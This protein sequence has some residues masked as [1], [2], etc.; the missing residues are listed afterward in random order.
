MGSV[1]GRK[2]L[3]EA[4]IDPLLPLDQKWM[5]CRLPPARRKLSF[6]HKIEED[7][8]VRS[9]IVESGVE[10][11]KKGEGGSFELVIAKAGMEELKKTL[12]L[13]MPVEI[14]KSCP[15]LPASSSSQFWRSWRACSACG[16]WQT[17]HSRGARQ[18]PG[19]RGARR[20]AASA[21]DT[22]SVNRRRRFGISESYI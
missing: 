9:A 22:H 16:G 17:L 12:L 6:F 18:H 7:C 10:E 13:N 11:L 15:V 20:S 5:S 19:R 14:N 1:G 8:W 21:S 3:S 2:V 4:G